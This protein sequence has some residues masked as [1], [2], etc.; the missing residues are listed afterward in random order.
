MECLKKALKIA[1]ICMSNPKNLYLFITILNK[2]VYYFSIDTCNFVR[3]TLI[4]R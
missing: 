3:K 2:Y 1:D 4:F